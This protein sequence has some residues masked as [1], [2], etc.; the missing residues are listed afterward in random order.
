METNWET[1][2]HIDVFQS[3]RLK[4]ML[5][6]QRGLYIAARLCAVCVLLLV[7]NTLMHF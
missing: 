3:S 2:I 6:L 5:S 4:I 7:S 1:L